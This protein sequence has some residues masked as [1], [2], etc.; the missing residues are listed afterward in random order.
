[1]R[2]AALSLSLSLA[3]QRYTVAHL[4]INFRN[5]IF[6]ALNST[7]RQVNVMRDRQVV[8]KPQRVVSE[9]FVKGTHGVGTD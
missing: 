4:L 1:V 7:Q 8:R 2:S 6:G 5:F 3:I 9:A